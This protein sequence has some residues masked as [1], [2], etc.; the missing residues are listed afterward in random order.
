MKLLVLCMSDSE[1]IVTLS[2]SSLDLSTVDKF[3]FW[4]SVYVHIIFCGHPRQEICSF[5][6]KGV[7]PVT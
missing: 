4:Q 6:G 7:K 1:F 3:K 5:G 2:C